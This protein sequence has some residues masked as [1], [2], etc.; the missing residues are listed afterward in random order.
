VAYDHNMINNYDH[1]QGTPTP[2][3]MGSKNSEGHMAGGTAGYKPMSAIK[4]SYSYAAEH[5]PG[6]ATNVASK[7][8]DSGIARDM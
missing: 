4:G 8:G 1:L 7:K 3:H 2:S 6:G 5:N